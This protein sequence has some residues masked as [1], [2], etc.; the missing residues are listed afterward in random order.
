[1]S[2]LQCRHTVPCL[3]AQ[4]A[5]LVLVVSQLTRKQSGNC[6]LIWFVQ[7]QNA[8]NVLV[9][10]APIIMHGCAAKLADL[11]ECCVQSRLLAGPTDVQVTVH[12][13]RCSAAVERH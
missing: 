13:A 10:S 2:S 7:L 8:R 5:S 4:G 9:A 1:M 3:A 11:G 12:T 6:R